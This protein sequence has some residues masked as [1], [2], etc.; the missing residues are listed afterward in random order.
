MAK[1]IDSLL[2][3][4]SGKVGRVVV[5]NLYGTEILRK[6][7]RKRTSEPTPKQQLVQIRMALSYQFLN[8]YKEFAKKYFGKRLGMKSPYNQAMTSVMKAFKLD[9][10]L[11][12]ITPEYNKIEF[13]KGDLMAPLPI[14]L[15]SPDPNS[16][17][18]EWFDN[19]GGDSDRE[20]DQLQVLFIAE[21]E[22]KPI[23]ME[24]VATRVDTSTQI[25]VANTL[26]GKNLHVWMSFIDADGIQA[27]DSAYAGT[28]LIT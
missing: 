18:I 8:P 6:R 3:G 22:A 7:P 26:S 11:M 17:T 24:N 23:L 9:F 1:L 16:F 27:A 5:S 20:N 21:G 4:S 10:D 19:S 14:G 25:P 28:V 13:T 2:S 12:E 15:S